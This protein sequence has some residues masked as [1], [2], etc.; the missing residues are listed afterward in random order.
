M[1]WEDERY[2][3]VFTRDTAELIA[4]GW[5]ARALLWELLRKAD[6][7]GLVELGRT[8]ARGVAGLTGIPLEVVERAL[9]ILLEDGCVTKGDGRL[10]LPNYIAAQETPQSDKARKREQRERARS[11]ALHPVTERDSGSQNVNKSHVRSREVT[12]GH[13]VPC[14]A[15]PDPPVGPPAGDAPTP[16][17]PRRRGSRQRPKGPRP[18]TWQPSVGHYEQGRKGSY[19]VVRIDAEAVRFRDHHDSKGNLFADWDAAFRTWIGNQ[20]RWDRERGS[21]GPP[22]P[23]ASG[24][25]PPPSS[26][27]APFVSPMSRASGGSP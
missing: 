19:D 24:A 16:E 27:N 21:S 22:T 10:V 14:R 1:R 7:A 23:P 5:E 26:G 17:E 18:P 6:R 12:S 25:M 4:L 13:S 3:R 9:P 2:V 8:G 11:D 15:V 20:I